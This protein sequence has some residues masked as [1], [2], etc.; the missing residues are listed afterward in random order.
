MIENDK[1]LDLKRILNGDGNVAVISYLMDKYIDLNDQ[2]GLL[3][4]RASYKNPDGIPVTTTGGYEALSRKA[5]KDKGDDATL[6]IFLDGQHK[7]VEMK[8]YY[9]NEFSVDLVSDL[10]TKIL[11]SPIAGIMLYNKTNSSG[12]PNRLQKKRDWLYNLK[13]ILKNIDVTIIDSMTDRITEVQGE[14][15]FRR[16]DDKL[17]HGNVPF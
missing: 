15:I 14:T 16:E 13:T 17:S 4:E 10:Y 11:N 3:H 6:F 5:F 8:C 9:D 1:D 12:L 2:L 7:I